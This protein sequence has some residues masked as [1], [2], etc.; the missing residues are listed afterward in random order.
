MTAVTDGVALGVFVDSRLG[1]AVGVAVPAV[2]VVLAVAVGLGV[3]VAVPGETVTVFVAVAVYVGVAVRLLVDV[4]VGVGVAVSGGAGVALAVGV[5]E[6]VGLRTGGTS[7]KVTVQSWTTDGICTPF[8]S[9]SEWY[10]NDKVNSP[11][12]E[13]CNCTRASGPDP[14]AGSCGLSWVRA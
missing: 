6:G 1:V 10:T 13:G 4:A 3:S 8:R 11:A 2:G 12:R 14:V 5:G 9:D 7:E